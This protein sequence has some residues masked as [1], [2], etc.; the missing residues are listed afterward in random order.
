MNK[1][2]YNLVQAKNNDG[3]SHWI[4]IGIAQ[5]TGD[6][7]WVKMDVL[8]IPNEKGEVWLNLYE[9]TDDYVSEKNVE[10]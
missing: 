2:R 1:I 4:K 6:K 8:P 5:K 3:K 9:R 7:F 10:K